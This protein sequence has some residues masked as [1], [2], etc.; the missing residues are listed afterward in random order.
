M[1]SLR[2]VLTV[3]FVISALAIIII[4]LLQEGKAGGLGGITG[5]NS[6]TFWA[7]NKKHS[8]EGRFELA[9]KLIAAVFMISALL[10]GVV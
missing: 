4:V 10:L 5:E 3:I 6:G 8:L 2:L 9:T 1:D 7:Q